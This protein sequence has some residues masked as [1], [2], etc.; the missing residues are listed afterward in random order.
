MARLKGRGQVALILFL[1]LPGCSL[2][3]S[4]AFLPS[5]VQQEPITDLTPRFS[6]NLQEFLIVYYAK[7]IAQMNHERTANLITALLV[8]PEILFG[9]TALAN[10]SAGPNVK[11]ATRGKRAQ[12]LGKQ[13]CVKFHSLSS[14][15]AEFTYGKRD[16][17]SLTCMAGAAVKISLMLFSCCDFLGTD[18]I[19]GHVSPKPHIQTTWEGLF[20]LE[21]P[22]I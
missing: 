5:S 21:V 7:R 2:K 4:P 17:L 11:R 20:R 22:C 10:V 9:T 3:D 8:Y 1:A 12:N 13:V 6:T 16:L 19:S 15:L 18:D 14:H